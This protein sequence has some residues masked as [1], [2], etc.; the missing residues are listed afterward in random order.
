MGPEAFYLTTVG[1][2]H[3]A[4]FPW[5]VWGR[6]L[7]FHVPH[8]FSAR[9]P[10]G[11]AFRRGLSTVFP[12]RTIELKVKTN[13]SV[14][15]NPDLPNSKSA[16]SRPAGRVLVSGGLCSGGELFTVSCSA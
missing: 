15:M 12:Q 8:S 13:A 3:S 10:V 7:I 5:W 14:T 1:W 2:R 9:L 4:E 6:I 16:T 11:V